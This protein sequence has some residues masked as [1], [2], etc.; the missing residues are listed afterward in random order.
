[1]DVF[2]EAIIKVLRDGRSRGFQQVLEEVG[3]LHNTLR[4]HLESL[5]D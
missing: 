1:M 3:F 4:L 2:D 5:I